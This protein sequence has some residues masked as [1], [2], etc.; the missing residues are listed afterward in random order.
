MSFNVQDNSSANYHTNPKPSR[1]IGK[2][3]EYERGMVS[4]QGSRDKR[5]RCREC[6]GFGHYQADCPNFLK[7]QSKG[8]T[9][10]LSDDDYESNSDSDEEI[11]ALMR[12]LSPKDSNVTSP[13]DIKTPVVLEKT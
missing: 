6:E 4:S 3:P 8:Y 13:S 12:C 9:V 5:F 11:R 1:L 7:R 10:T 2:K